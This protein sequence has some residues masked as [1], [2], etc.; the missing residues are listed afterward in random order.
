MYVDLV[1][2]INIR[3]IQLKEQVKSE[4]LG[5]FVIIHLVIDKRQYSST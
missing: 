1:G 2:S 4:K 3:Q 5:D